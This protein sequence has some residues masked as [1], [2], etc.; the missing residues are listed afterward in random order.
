MATYKEKIEAEYETIKEILS[1]L[2]KGSIENLNHLELAG[3]AILLCNF[4]NGMENILKQVF[5]M[6]GI[7]IPSGYSWHRDMINQALSHKII[8]QS[9]AEHLKKYLA[10][11]HYI[12]HSYAI[13]LDVR[14]I[15]TLID[16]IDVVI[17]RFRDEVIEKV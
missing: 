1:L 2:P 3:V 9:L 13:D 6:R 8:S 4:Y 5:K 7:S 12:V 15:K 10:F 17:D 11:R 14:K 16:G